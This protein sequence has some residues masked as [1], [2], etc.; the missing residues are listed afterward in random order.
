MKRKLIALLMA[1][2]MLVGANSQAS[3]MSSCYFYVGGASGRLIIRNDGDTTLTAAGGDYGM[4]NV[5]V[6][7]RSWRYAGYAEDTVTATDGN[8]NVVC[9]WYPNAKG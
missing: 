3:A 2:T 5:T 6:P 7:A 8:G 1:V 9:G 4:V